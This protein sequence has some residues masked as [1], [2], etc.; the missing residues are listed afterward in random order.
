MGRTSFVVQPRWSTQHKSISGKPKERHHNHHRGSPMNHRYV[1]LAIILLPLFM[2]PAIVARPVVGLTARSDAPTVDSRLK[3]EIQSSSG[4]V[5]ALLEFQDTLTNAQIIQAEN[6]GIEFVRRG[7]TIVNVGEVYSAE[8]EDVSSLD[9]LSSLGLVRATSGSKQYVPSITSS[10]PAIKADDV[11]TNLK[12]DGGQVN[13]SGVRVAVLDTGATWMHPSFWRASPGEYRAID[14]GDHYFVDLNG[15][16]IEQSGEGPIAAVVDITIGPDFDYSSDYMYINADGISGFNY[17]SGDRW[18]GG[19]DANHDNLINLD[20][21]NVV[22]LDISKVAILYDQPNSKVYVRGVNLTQAV[23]VLDNNGHGTHVAST[24]AGGQ[25]GM[26]SYVGVAPGADLIIIKSD[27]QSAD[28]LDG[29]SF[30]IENDANIINMSFSSYLGFLDGTDLEDLA[31]T[32]AFLKHNLITVAAAGNLADKS[33]HAHFSAV[34]GGQGSARLLVTSPPA[35]SF[36]SLLWHSSDDD[37]HVILTLNGANPIDLGAFSQVA[38]RSWA[39]DTEDLSAYVF[40]D[41]GIRGINSL[42][43]Q[44]SSAEHHW[45]N[46]VWNITITNEMGEPVDVDCYAWDGQ[47]ETSHMYFQTALDSG[48]TISSPGTADFAVTVAAYS[49]STSGIMSSS[50]RGPRVD[51]A[52]KPTVAAPGDNIRA[53]RNSV[54][55]PLWTT[56]EG[57]SMA[58]PHVAGVLALI[59]Q[60]SGGNSAW[61][62]YSALVNGAGGRTSH[63]ETAST[64]WGHGLVDALWSVVQ[65]LGSPGMDG[66]TITDWFGVDELIADG[67]NASILGGQDITSV[68]SFVDNDTISFAVSMRGTPN[69]QGSDVLSIEWD[70]DSNVGTGQ[71]GADIVVNITEGLANVYEWNGSSYETSFLTPHWWTNSM[72]VFV[73]LEGTPLGARGDISLSTHNS[74]MANIDQAGPES[75]TDFLL[76]VMNDLLLEYNDGTMLVHMT[77][78]DRDSSP[79]LRS[80]AW[81]IV[82]GPLT[83]LNSSSRSGQSDIDIAVPEALINSPYLNGLL[84]NVTSESFTLFLPLVLLSTRIAARMSFTETTLD[85]SVVRVGFLMN[86]KISG[87]LVLDGFTLASHVYVAFHSESGVWLNFTLSSNNGFYHFEISPS[88]FQLGSH[89]VYAIAI[90]QAVPGTEVNFATLTVVQDYSVLVIGVASLIVCVVLIMIMRRRKGEIV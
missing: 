6:M 17:A 49:E 16:S 55:S 75:L 61:L 68:K 45:T 10:V 13:G 36:L 54:L 67:T 2:T 24:I 84:I 62:D 7:S 88:Y 72:T 90:G 33:K 78:G 1:I 83:I 58:S 44:I 41:V 80:V 9:K 12:K 35:Y 74:T 4:G 63:Y 37:E 42:I 87:E 14:S 30:A 29:I 28:I 77:V 71:N 34:T 79:A 66:S 15:D 40:A 73:R 39:L 70:T 32:E 26:T 5:R 27:L 23:S 86:D 18:I 76:P 31:V 82:N 57:T 60:A 46:G 64:S 51:G 22:L 56:K 85:W 20:T 25:I 59:H 11:W 89:D 47:W 53:A 81:S 8:V 19:I 38:D 21:E 43:I 50:S 48:R 52:P 65:V 3:A 69:F